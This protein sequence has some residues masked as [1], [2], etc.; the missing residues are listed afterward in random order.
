MLD[1]QVDPVMFKSLHFLLLLL[2]VC[3]LSQ[4]LFEINLDSFGSKIKNDS[5]FANYDKLRVKKVNKTHHLVVGEITHH[6]PMDN[7]YIIECHLYQKAG[8]D[9][10]LT[11]YKLPKKP[12]CD[13]IQSD[14]LFMPEVIKA[15]DLP[16]QDTVKESVVMMKM[17]VL[18]IQFQCP[19]PA[20][21]YH[22]HGYELDFSKI[23]S[24]RLV[25]K[26]GSYRSTTI[27]TKDD[28]LLQEIYINFDVINILP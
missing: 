11:P 23:Q 10:K 25:L 26:S 24:A 9:Y 14:V 7:S 18:L 4:A 16:P 8:N 5:N 22:F 15:S 2:V 21:T 20:G 19:F 12:F 13:G 6:I 3:N 28:E 17:K 27:F 1:S